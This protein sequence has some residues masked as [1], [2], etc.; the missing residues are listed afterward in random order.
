[1]SSSRRR[2]YVGG[3][4]VTGGEAAVNQQR[5]FRNRRL[6]AP[7]LKRETLFSSCD[8]LSAATRYDVTYDDGT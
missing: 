8:W 5:Q 2:S 1:M 3:A 4:A 7:S 6:N